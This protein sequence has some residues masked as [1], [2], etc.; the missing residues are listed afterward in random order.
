MRPRS[1]R[2]L[3]LSF[4]DWKAR[5]R[6]FRERGG[7]RED[8]LRGRM[9]PPF[10]IFNT[11]SNLAYILA[12]VL[13]L[14]WDRSAETWVFAGALC[15]LGVFSGLYHALKRGWA[16]RLDQFGIYLVLGAQGVLGY[17]GGHSWTWIAMLLTGWGLGWLI[18]YKLDHKQVEGPAAV[19]I[20]MSFLPGIAMGRWELIGPLGL[21]I[22]SYLCWV[23]DKPSGPGYLGL[24]GHACWHVG[25]AGALAWKHVLDLGVR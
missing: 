18:V 17:A 12:G 5:A 22:A 24:L 23:D 20:L 13:L 14:V 8:L 9:S 6:Q 2:S 10:G 15:L 19:L 11:W 4:A 3:S 1:R 16:N 21:F 25:T 7:W